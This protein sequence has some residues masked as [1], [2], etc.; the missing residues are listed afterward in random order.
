MS[1]G[2]INPPLVVIRALI[3]KLRR[4]IYDFILRYVNRSLL[5]MQN[6]SLN[7]S[8]FLIATISELILP[9]Y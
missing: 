7:I 6:A 3:S 9:T 2:A 1:N 8:L 4:E 5:T